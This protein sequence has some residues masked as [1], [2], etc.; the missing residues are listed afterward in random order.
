MDDP[1]G[2]TADRL[3]TILKMHGPQSAIALGEALEITDEAARQQLLNFATK[4]SSRHFLRF[5]DSAGQN[6]YGN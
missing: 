3:L 1:A 6:R 2:S 4:A 5:V